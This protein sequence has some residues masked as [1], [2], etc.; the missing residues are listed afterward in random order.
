[1]SNL[2]G[3]KK[4]LGHGLE[5]LM[6]TEYSENVQTDTAEKAIPENQ[7]FLKTK[8]DQTTLDRR[9]S[10]KEKIDFL[11]DRISQ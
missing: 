11:R 7:D 9:Q 4:R 5:A 2:L 8:I 1:M 10:I 6:K 3:E